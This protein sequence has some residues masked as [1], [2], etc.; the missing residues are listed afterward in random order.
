[1]F[2]DTIT[3]S[4]G[5]EILKLSFADRK[6]LK[7]TI[8]LYCDAVKFIN[9]VISENIDDICAIPKTKDKYNYIEHLI[10]STSENTAKYPE[11]DK[12]FLNMPC[13]LRRDA[14]AQAWGHM[15]SYYSNLKNYNEERYEKISNGKY[16]KKKAPTLC[17]TPNIMPTFFKNN[18]YIPIEGNCIKLKL[19]NGKVWDYHTLTLRKTDCD[20][21][22]KVSGK[23]CNPS[24][25]FRNNKFY[26]RYSFQ[27]PHVL[28]PIKPVKYRVI[29]A[30]DL[31]VNTHATCSVMKSDGTIIARRFITDTTDKATLVFLLD[32][33]HEL[34]RKSGRWDYA[35]LTHIQNKINNVNTAIEN[36]TCNMIIEMAKEFN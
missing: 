29:L 36:Y 12:R 17:L 3:V 35:P 22:K 7:R 31:G 26:I 25:E 30:I 24:L 32:K 8:V 6:I 10:H 4:Y 19:Y 5:A 1:M 11:F 27:Q 2:N 20:Y 14:I 16:F 15:S 18:M 21:L 34:Q 33:K 13:Y 9:N 23:R 28:C